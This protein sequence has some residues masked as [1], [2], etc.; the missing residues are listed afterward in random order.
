RGAVERRS[1][2]RGGLRDACGR[3]ALGASL[4]MCSGMA[5]Y[6]PRGLGRRAPHL[7]AELHPPAGDARR[8]REGVPADAH[9]VVRHREDGH[10][11]RVHGRRVT[12]TNVS[13]LSPASS[14]TFEAASQPNA[15]P[16]R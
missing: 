8:A 13:A 1:R 7:T 5:A 15:F 10:V 2:I 14:T 6:E 16:F 3:T 11:D 4:R 12:P 9:A